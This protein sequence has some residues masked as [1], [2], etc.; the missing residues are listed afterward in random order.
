VLTAFIYSGYTSEDNVKL[1][2]HLYMAKSLCYVV[3]IY[4]SPRSK[5]LYT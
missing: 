2:R 4:P 5:N 3:R 1:R